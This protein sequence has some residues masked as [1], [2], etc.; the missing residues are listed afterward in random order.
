[1]DG[2]ELRPYQREA[3][4]A[5]VA[6]IILGKSGVAVLPT[7]SG[8]SLVLAEVIIEMRRRWPD[9]RI[10]VLTHRQELVEQDYAAYVRLGGQDAGIISA[11]LGRFDDPDLPII[12]AGVQSAVPRRNE[13]GSRVIIFID[14]AHS[15]P[16]KLSPDSRY[17]AIWNHFSEAVKIGFTATPY[18]LDGGLIVG[19][20]T[21]FPAGIAIQIGAKTLVEQDYLAALVGLKTA[22]EISTSAVRVRGGEFVSADLTEAATADEKALRRSVREAIRAVEGRR[23]VLAFAVSVLHAE[24]IVEALRMEGESAFAVHGRMT[25]TER[26]E[27]LESF[28]DGGG[29]WLVNCEILTTG[30]DCPGIDAICC[31]RPTQSKALWVQ[32][33]GRGMRLA[34]GKH[35]CLVIDFGENISRHGDIDLFEKL[36]RTQERVLRDNDAA[37]RARD[38]PR[39]AKSAVGVD[40]MTGLPAGAFGVQIYSINYALQ[41]AKNVADATN[42]VATYSTQLGPVRR[43]LCPEYRTGAAWHARR[44]A[45]ARGITA[46]KPSAAWLVEQLRGC[47]TLPTHVV[48]AR[49]GK[50]Y[51]VVR[52]IWAPPSDP[53]GDEWGD[54]A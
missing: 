46:W 50:F 31:W 2:I 29:R 41:A 4:A 22:S 10:L 11:G 21:P 48:L 7:G 53:F 40:P 49:P 37:R 27:T 13:L 30:Y 14:E 43:W 3:V 54:A 18:R 25:R 35:D 16:L 17:G 52:E 1:M 33:L 47:A 20:G 9:C 26:A 44:F 32:M 34:P 8:K 36:G 23:R 51:E 39:P 19:P 45:A 42:I 6:A 38:L 28:A 5:A 12:F 24:M 15:V